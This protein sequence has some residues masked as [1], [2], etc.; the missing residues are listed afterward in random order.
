MFGF[1][2]GK[3][4]IL[5]VGSFVVKSGFAQMAKG[6]LVM[7]VINAEQARIAQDAGVSTDK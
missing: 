6:G 2:S 4:F 1:F 3:L 7:D 5:F